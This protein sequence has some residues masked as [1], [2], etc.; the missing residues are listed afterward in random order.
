MKKHSLIVF[1]A[2]AFLLLA[3]F[4]STHV[5][6]GGSIYRLNESGFSY[7]QLN[8]QVFQDEVPPA[9]VYDNAP[10]LIAVV[11]R[12][13]IEGYVWKEELIPEHP[14]SPEE[15]IALNEGGDRQIPMYESD[16]VTFIDWFEC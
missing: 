7:G 16:G 8:G 4:W 5:Y 2:A 9:S 12:S 6:I 15:A 13:G 14:S 1:I 11:N 10:D 3:Y